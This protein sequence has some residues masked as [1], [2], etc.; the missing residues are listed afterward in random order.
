[1]NNLAIWIA[2]IAALFS[3]YFASCNVALKTFNRIRL[4]EF[5]H[6]TGR[7]GRVESLID[8]IPR[9]LLMTGTLRTCLNLVVLLSMVNLF[10]RYLDQWA[11]YLAAFA[12]A[13]ILVSVFGVAIPVSWGR[14]HPE[15]LLA[16]SIPLLNTAMILFNPIVTALHLF[17][18]I[19]RRI[20][21]ADIYRDD[22]DQLSNQILSVVEEHND[23][24]GRVDDAQKQMIEAVVEFPS[25]TAD[26]I[27]TPRTDVRGLSV[28]A[29]L[30]QI[31]TFVIHE[32]HSRIPIYEN[33]LDQILGLLYV[34]DLLPHIGNDQPFELRSVLREVLMV[35]ET[36]SVRE[37]LAEFKSR[38]VHIAIVLDEYGG[39]AGLVTIEDI[40]EEIVGEI[41]DEYEPSTREPA[42][43]EIDGTT[44]EVDAR[45]D[46]NDFS[47]ELNIRLPED[48]DYDTVGGFVF[49]TLGHIPDVGEQFEFDQLRLTVID[50]ERTKVNRIR[51]ERIGP[52]STTEITGDGSN[53][54]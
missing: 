5:L 4:S 31:K 54:T 16:Y 38:K 43:D 10:G 49:A 45:V 3:C 52:Q 7:A 25:T 18:P 44:L 1:M 36:K 29:T 2:L 13:G 40:I 9:L 26:Q 27:M 37:L 22:D 30:E 21:G 19:I 17:D 23:E 48:R 41:Q 53:D 8:Q 33:S 42:I 20:T 51:V 39:T 24:T 50:A 6:K 35:P 11:Q 28:D 34:K 14:Y 12:V 46:I 15:R 47:D 32:G